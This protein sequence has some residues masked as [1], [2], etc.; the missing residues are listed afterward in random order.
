M[1]DN[2]TLTEQPG[3]KFE[4]VQLTFAEN[5]YC[6]KRALGKNK[7][8]AY[9]L[10][11]PD[12]AKDPEKT[13]SMSARRLELRPEIKARIV[14]WVLDKTEEEKAVFR[15]DRQWA[16]DTT[17]RQL[18]ALALDPKAFAMFGLKLMEFLGKLEGWFTD[19]LE[20]TATDTGTTSG[21]LDNAEVESKIDRLLLMMTRHANQNKENEQ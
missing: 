16:I 5:V 2:L 21:Q 1:A 19:R 8:E 20:I 15:A 3:G 14:E 4:Y 12:R 11:F 17:R 9:L 13:I 6:E 7:R 18:K 10:A